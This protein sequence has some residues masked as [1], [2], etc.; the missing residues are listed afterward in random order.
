MVRYFSFIRPNK[1]IYLFPVTLLTVGKIDCQQFSQ[2][3]DITE[4][5]ELYP[6]L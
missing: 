4:L 1:I 5:T 2:L 6:Y 3:T